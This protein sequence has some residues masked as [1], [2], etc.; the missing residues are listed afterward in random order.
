MFNLPKIFADTSSIE[1]IEALV[2]LGIVSG[3][4]TNPLIVAKEAK[5]QE[6]NDYYQKLTKKFP[7]LPISIQLLDEGLE[8]LLSQARKY[9]KIAP[10]VVVKIPMFSGG[11]GLKL[12][13]TLTQE[14]IPTNVTAL[15]T[16]DQAALSLVAGKG[17]GP[18]YVSLFYNRIKDGGGNPEKE[19]KA[20]REMIDKFGSRAEI[21]AG[22][23]RSGEDVYKAATF[24]AH[25]ITVAPKV[26]WSMIEHPKS[27]EFISQSQKAWDEF[28]AKNSKKETPR[29]KY[30]PKSSKFA[31]A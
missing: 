10:N 25:I 26:I 6:P 18:Q 16:A 23:I 9:A 17:S 30:L 29:K 15:M 12:I 7:N 31:T 14:N 20:T 21:I 13:S 4:T 5:E 28:I 2:N 22:S 27:A 3:I 8:D 11:K 19:I 1:E 24:G